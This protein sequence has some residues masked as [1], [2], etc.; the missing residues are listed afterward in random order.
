MQLQPAAA[1]K[2]LTNVLLVWTEVYPLEQCFIHV[3]I[4]ALSSFIPYTLTSHIQP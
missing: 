1:R 2:W 4:K 3:D